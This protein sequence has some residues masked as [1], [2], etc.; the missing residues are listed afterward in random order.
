MRKAILKK[1]ILLLILTVSISG[2]FFYVI[3]SHVILNNTQE[4]MRLTLQ[5]LDESID[6][7]KDL[8]SQIVSLK[9][10]V[11]NKITRFTILKEDGS[12]CADSEV[13][14]Y[15]ELE[16]HGDREEI[17]EAK[18]DGVGYSTRYSSTLETK[19]MY[20]AMQSDKSD[21]YLRVAIPFSGPQ[22]Y[23]I[24]LM[25]AILISMVIALVISIIFAENLTKSITKPLSDVTKKLEDF[26]E[27]SELKFEKYKYEELNVIADTV[28]K[29][30]ES[31]RT[32]TES[33]KFEKMVRQEF[34][35]N[36]SHEL[37]T[38]ITS[39][40]GY[41]ELLQGDFAKD[42][43]TKEEFMERIIKETENMTTL[44]ND[45][46]MISRLETHEA[47]MIVSEVRISILLGDVIKTLKPYA[48]K[49]GITFH[50]ECKPLI[51]EA[52]PQ[53]MR[54][55]LINLISNAVKYNKLGGKVEISIVSEGQDLDIVVSDTG[56]GIP[57]E[58]ISRIFERFYR[59]DKGRS[60]KVGGTGLGLS[61]VK[62]IVNYY[63]GTI[64]VKSELE[65]G[66]RFEVRIPDIVNSG[67][68]NTHAESE[69][70][71]DLKIG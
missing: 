57:E 62:H 60:K 56:V 38:P 29:M 16:N 25:P 44:I 10:L 33:I 50:V 22:Q 39:I 31:I 6:Y 9:K 32:Y 1:F 71:E 24:L 43:Q 12:V 30:S 15:E 63:N 70:Q 20:I 5:M 2:A 13:A 59:V 64:E 41:M 18:K 52:N 55:L 19:M 49:N 51:I 45:I 17:V 65:K 35:T 47:E 28:T 7:E 53:Q 66:S 36:V 58:C 26:K 68:E 3:V 67:I 21:Y 40:R 8:Q 54:E 37:K 11:D 69:D 48:D 4:D 14:D 34:F 46:L 23:L 27:N 42:E 61:I